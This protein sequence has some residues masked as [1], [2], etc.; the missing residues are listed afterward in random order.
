MCKLVVPVS[1][2]RNF[3]AKDLRSSKYRLRVAQSKKAFNRA[4]EKSMLR[5]E[6]YA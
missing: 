5:K 1:K 6:F 3:V 2:P 4:A